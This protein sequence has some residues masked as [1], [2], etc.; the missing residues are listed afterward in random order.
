[1]G[2]TIGEIAIGVSFTLQLNAK[3]PHLAA[4]RQLVPPSGN[5]NTP[6]PSR[7]RAVMALSDERQHVHEVAPSHINLSVIKEKA[8][9]AKELFGSVDGSTSTPP[10]RH[11]PQLI[12][13]PT[14]RRRRRR[15]VGDTTVAFDLMNKVDDLRRSIPDKDFMEMVDI[16]QKIHNI[17]KHAITFT[18]DSGNHFA[19]FFRSARTSMECHK[20]L[21]QTSNSSTK[22]DD[23]KSLKRK[24]YDAFYEAAVSMKMLKSDPTFQLFREIALIIQFMDKHCSIAHQNCTNFF[25]QKMEKMQATPEEGSPEEGRPVEVD[26]PNT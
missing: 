11:H 18:P 21:Q 25:M 10:S 5:T 19:E 17:Q 15:V 16:T 13:Q 3:S 22:Q 14:P 24:R 4:R 6:T 12:T 1:M 8:R 9:I 20:S 7:H 2:F 23:L 26:K